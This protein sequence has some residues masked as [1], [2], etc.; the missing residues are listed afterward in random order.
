MALDFERLSR[1]LKENVVLTALKSA[2]TADA[3]IVGGFLRDS[4]LGR[5]PQDVDLVICG[6]FELACAQVA[7][8]LGREPFQLG[9]RFASRRVLF[10]GFIVDL[11][12]IYES[13]LTEDLSRRD[14]TIN[15]LCLPLKCVGRRVTRDDLI[16]SFGGLKDLEK[17][18]ITAISEKSLRED[19]L[20]MLRAFRFALELSFTIEPITLKL[21]EIRGNE[22]ASVAGER[23]RE[24]LLRILCH[25]AS[26]AVIQ[27]M[28]KVGF[29]FCLFPELD[30]TRG[31]TQNEYHHLPVFE[32]SLECVKEF[33]ALI[34]DWDGV[35]QELHSPI[36]EHLSE[37]VTP[38]GTRS[39]LVKLALL[40]H[41]IGKPATR[42][43]QADGKVTFYGHQKVGREIVEPI[44]D[45]LRMSARE[46][47]LVLLLIE[48]HLRVGFYCNESPITPKLI[49]RFERRLGDA[50]VMSAV[51][52]LADARATRGPAADEVFQKT[53]LEVVNEILWHHFF[54]KEITEPIPLLTGDDIMRVT[55]IPESPRIGELK[56]A[57]LEA[58]VEGKVKTRADAEEFVLKLAREQMKTENSF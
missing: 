53:H 17:Q 28:V 34:T 47:D 54:G 15:A 51:H 58:Q 3:Y 24:E 20:R 14:F 8:V 19:P 49:H 33:E 37:V 11:S 27:Q 36:S 56:E 5:K 18:E 48:E 42:Q 10:D 1:E 9:E 31:V 25:S 23:I 2:L 26:F 13:N 40:F 41:D 46:K 7:K 12:P 21:I 30:I 38:P 6:D 50:T 16:D 22:I 39:A 29:L 32:H 45:R 4:L 57:L 55:G 44:L 52:A 35:R 43:M